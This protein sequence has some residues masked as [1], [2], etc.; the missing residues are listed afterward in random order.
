MGKRYAN[1]SQN[2]SNR[3]SESLLSEVLCHQV[4]SQGAHGACRFDVGLVDGRPA[5]KKTR[6]LILDSVGLDDD[7]VI[8]TVPK[9]ARF[10][11]LASCQTGDVVLVKDVEGFR[12]GRI[13]FHCDGEGKTVSFI[14]PY[15]FYNR[16]PNTALVTWQVDDHIEPSE[17]DE[18]L[19]A[20]EYISYASA[21]VGTLLPI[22][23][24]A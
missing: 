18:I 4:A 21:R 19:S 16:T 7:G 2:T 23:R 20:V 12:A 1:D 22:G 11:K 6:K 8:V 15:A 14:Q 5:P 13:Q 10:N 9:S 17:A 24:N 3:A